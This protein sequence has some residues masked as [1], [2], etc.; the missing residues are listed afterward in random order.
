M[1]WQAG[2]F[3]DTHLKDN[4][5]SQSEMLVGPLSVAKKRRVAWRQIGCD[6]II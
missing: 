2:P 5:K 4:I 3:L 1:W 6:D